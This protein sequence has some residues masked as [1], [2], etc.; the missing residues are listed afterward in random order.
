MPNF[1]YCFQYSDEYWD[2]HIGIPTT[3]QFDRIIT[4]EGEISTQHVGYMYELIAER[5]LKEAVK[6]DEFKD[7][8]WPRRGKKLE[9]NAFSAFE[10]K[11][12]INI[13]HVGF[14]TENDDTIYK[15]GSSP[16]FLVS[17]EERPMQAGEIKCPA[18]WTHIG[19]MLDGP[20]SANFRKKYKQQVQGQMLVGGFDKIYF[21]SYH[22]QMP[23]YILETGRDERYLKKMVNVLKQFCELLANRLVEVRKM[24]EFI[25]TEKPVQPV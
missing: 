19:Y 2:L 6:K 17:S 4:G 22:P 15:I 21:V 12:N 10:N 9:S 13:E 14:I 20:D 1:H 25:V 23:L 16:D 11:K 7:L 3:S 24:G 5:L 18:P 8:Y